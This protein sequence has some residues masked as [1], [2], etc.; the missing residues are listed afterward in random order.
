M[1]RFV[2]LAGL[3]LATPLLRADGLGDLRTGLDRLS[4]SEPIRVRVAISRTEVE[5]EKPKGPERKGE[6]VVEHG[7]AGLSIHLDPASLPKPG[8]RVERKAQEKSTVRLDPG[9][10]LKLVDPA[11]ELR[12]LLDGATLLSDRTEAFEGRSLRTLV[13][14]P[15]VDMD[16]DDRKSVKRYEDLVTVRLDAEGV[17]VAFDRTVDMKISKLLLSFTVSHRESR[18][19]SRHG[20][21]LVTTTALSESRG[22]GLGQSSATTTRWAVTPL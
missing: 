15:V 2:L 6:A 22:S 21:R 5:K 8:S 13:F 16:E 9:E 11:A 17:P 18:R 12:S 14:K 1:R 7:P 19:F 10:A 20:G 3:L 4:A